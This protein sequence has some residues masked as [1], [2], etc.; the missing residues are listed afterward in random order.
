[1]IGI[2]LLGYSYYYIKFKLKWVL[3]NIME[4]VYTLR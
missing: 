3:C 2:L 1:M 4:D